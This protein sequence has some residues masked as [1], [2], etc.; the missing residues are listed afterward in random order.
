MF[1]TMAGVFE[2]AEAEGG[3]K[4][5]GESHGAGRANFGMSMLLRESDGFRF[6]QPILRCWLIE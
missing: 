1:T 5:A 3:K 2:T 6:A 4:A